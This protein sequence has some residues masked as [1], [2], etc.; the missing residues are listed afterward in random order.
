MNHA[1][2]LRQARARYARVVLRVTV[3]ELPAT[4]GEPRVAIDAVDAE[5]AR[6]PATDIVL[7]PEASLTGY[8]SPLGDFDLTPF[9]EPITGPTARAVREIAR[10]RGVVLIAP[11]V[12]RE[13]KACF[14]AM[15]ACDRAGELLF[16]Y[17]KRRPWFPEAWATPG[18]APAPVV[19][20]DGARVTIAICF[21]VHFLAA[22]A[23][24]A[25][26][27][28]DLLLFPSAW[29]DEDDT[30]PV[31]LAQLA[32]QYQ[33]AIANANWSAG[34]VTIAGQGA[35]SIVGANGQVLARA[36]SLLELASSHSGIA[37]A[38]AALEV[39][40]LFA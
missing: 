11:L 18:P 32:T 28:S 9:A 27:A 39:T 34:V 4:W 24:A 15:I 17:R 14:N 20:I 21:D 40:R 7:L 35:S 23:S 8:V 26:A 10:E 2:V 6:G 33:L 16:T 25:L 37:R 5:L 31:Q 38:D 1:S 3:L 29:V 30:R 19:T 36:P 12:L 22:D 13:G